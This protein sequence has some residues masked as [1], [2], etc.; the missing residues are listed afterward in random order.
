MTGTV[1]SEI[2]GREVWVVTVGEGASWQLAGV[3]SSERRAEAMIAHL[4][5]GDAALQATAT[6][7]RVDEELRPT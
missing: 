4:R 2:D 7:V 3:Y 5:D 1:D 6:M